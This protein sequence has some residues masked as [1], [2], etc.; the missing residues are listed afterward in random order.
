MANVTQKIPNLLGGVSRMSDFDKKPGELREAIN[1]YADLSYGM[2]KRPGTQF[3]GALGLT[4][5]ESDQT[6]FFPI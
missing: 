5:E 4:E 2:T 6:Y 1:S 3:V